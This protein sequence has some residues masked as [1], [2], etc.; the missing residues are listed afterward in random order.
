M[1]KWFASNFFTSFTAEMNFGRSSSHNH[2]RYTLPIGA[3]TTIDP[4]TAF[5]LGPAFGTFPPLWRP[6]RGGDLKANHQALN[7]A[8]SCFEKVRF[9]PSVKLKL[10]ML[11]TSMGS[12]V[13]ARRRKALRSVFLKLSLSC[14]IVIV[15]SRVSQR[16]TESRS[17]TIKQSW[18]SFVGLKR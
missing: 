14:L 10:E 2:W 6:R 11:S 13:C 7:R 16:V 5:I 3:V 15:I 18:D 17:A 8:Y 4:C 1:K 12:C 9:H